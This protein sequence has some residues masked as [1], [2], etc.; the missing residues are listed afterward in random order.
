M[1]TA[2]IVIHIFVS[3][4]MII[5]VLLQVGRG[6]GHRFCLWRRVK[7]DP[8]RKRGSAALLVKVTGVCAGIFMLTSLYLTYQ[9]SRAKQT[10]VMSDAPA[11]TAPAAP[12]VTAPQPDALP[13]PTV[14]K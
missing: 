12:Q 7:S 2:I 5:S 9:S 10:S 6:R 1:Y 11:V 14:N 3:I 13:Q 4:V 8:F